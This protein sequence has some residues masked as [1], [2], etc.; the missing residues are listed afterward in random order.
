MAGRAS[1]GD[2][3][4]VVSNSTGLTRTVTASADGSYRLPVEAGD[5]VF[6]IKPDGYRIPGAA[7]GLPA[8]WRH[9]VPQGSPALKYRG[10]GVEARVLKV[11]QT[12]T[13]LNEQP[14]VEFQLRFTDV[15][16]Q[17]Q[18]AVIRRYVP[19]LDLATIPR[20]T[21]QIIYDPG[22][23]SRVQMDQDAARRAWLCRPSWPAPSGPS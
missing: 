6:V 17:P 22:N 11:R 1:A 15:A 4:T 3:V 20:E 13:Y 23:P 12:G 5:T 8:F 19:L 21:M 7:D 14:Q 16:G 9:Y 10:I 18:R 2:Q